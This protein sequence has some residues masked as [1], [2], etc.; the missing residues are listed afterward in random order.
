MFK[1]LHIGDVHLNKTFAT[2]SEALRRT[3]HKRLQQAFI[4][5]VQYCIEEKLDALVI[6]GDL[7]DQ[8]SLS[9]QDKIFILEAFESL[10]KN[11]VRVLYASGNHDYTCEGSDVAELAYPDNVVT[12]FSATCMTYD[13]KAQDGEVYRIAGCGHEVEMESRNLIESFPQG[14]DLCIAHTMVAS[15]LTKGDEGQ[16]LPSTIETMES[17][18]AKYFALGH[19]HSGGPINRQGNICYA[20]A[21]QGLNRNEIGEKGGMLVSI[22][23]DGAT[24]EKVVFSTLVY[25]KCHIEVSD[26]QSEELLFDRLLQM[27]KSKYEQPERMAVSIY[28]EG[29]SSL[30]GQLKSEAYLEDIAEMLIER[31]DL[32]HLILKNDTHPI[33]DAATFIGK[34]S[35]LGEI[36]EYSRGLKGELPNINYLSSD[37]SDLKEWMIRQMEDEL[38]SYFLEGHDED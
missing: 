11:N 36:L 2:K 24:F 1:F 30:Y 19:V 20:G 14:M 38:M 18:G 6:A 21:L 35:V 7:F 17:K 13:L 26:Y 23:K 27:L 34:K 5:A 32:C 16:Y 33:Y 10:R 28:L 4:Q 9:H 29:K 22:D 31:T 25:E 15:P 12:F 3:L 37:T 8:N